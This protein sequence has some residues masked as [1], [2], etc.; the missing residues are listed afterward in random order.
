MHRVRD[1]NDSPIKKFILKKYVEIGR[2]AANEYVKT[3]VE[4]YKADAE[5]AILENGWVSFTHIE[6]TGTSATFREVADL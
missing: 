1:A 5:D 6:Q 4:G 3:M 2:K